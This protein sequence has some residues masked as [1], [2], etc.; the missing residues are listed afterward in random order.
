MTAAPPNAKKRDSD[1]GLALVLLMLLI[2]FFLE[3][4]GLVLP[5]IVLLVVTILWPAAFRPLSRIWYTLA[6]AVGTV[7]SALILSGLYISL[8]F[9]VGKLRQLK[10]SDP[11]RIRRWKK[12][13]GSVFHERNVT[14]RRQ[15]LEK[16]Y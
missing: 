5:T 8:V 13:D 12:N 1:T 11:M 16:P 7:G 6:E 3:N 2:M 14:Y 9:P 15:D 10:G 4:L